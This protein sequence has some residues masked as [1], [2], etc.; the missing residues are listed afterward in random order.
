MSPPGS[1]E[2]QRYEAAMAL[3]QSRRQRLRA[4]TEAAG[5]AGVAAHLFEQLRSKQSIAGAS[6]HD[7]DDDGAHHHLPVVTAS[8]PRASAAAPPAA[9]MPA[10]SSSGSLQ[11]WEPHSRMFSPSATTA[12]P[13][14]GAG[15]RA[16]GTAV[17][18]AGGAAAVRSG[19]ESGRSSGTYGSSELTSD[20]VNGAAAL[21]A[22]LLLSP[23]SRPAGTRM[24]DPSAG[25]LLSPAS[26]AV[27]AHRGPPIARGLRDLGPV[28]LPEALKIARPIALPDPSIFAPVQVELPAASVALRRARGGYR[29]DV[30]FTE[31]PAGITLAGAVVSRVEPGSIA[32]GILQPG[33]TLQRIGVTDVQ[34][35]VVAAQSR[36]A[37]VVCG[38]CDVSVLDGAAAVAN[39]RS[40]RRAAT[41]TL[42]SAA[43]SA[44]VQRTLAQAGHD[45]PSEVLAAAA[46]YASEEAP[47]RIRFFREGGVDSLPPF[48]AA[49]LQ[50]A[51]LGGACNAAA[52]AAAFRAHAATQTAGIPASHMLTSARSA[53]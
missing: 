17:G 26:R 16:R 31:P 29:F 6:N 40:S 7:A 51:A 9:P 13:S 10:P 15:A 1:L 42:Y 14:G 33:D 18:G 3:Q 47:L 37:R 34:R 43:T 25:S 22:A 39:G 36:A 44:R 28:E 48:A 2:R 12:T 41:A 21:P 19:A 32:D 45:A 35:A 23:S 4:Y 46:R 20:T 53:V 11:Q 49:A 5:L 52:S 50:V 8:A 24:G 27:L 30:A 38:P